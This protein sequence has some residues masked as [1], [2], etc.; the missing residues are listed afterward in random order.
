VAAV[1]W[2]SKLAAAVLRGRLEQEQEQLA[3]Q[4]VQNLERLGPTFV[5]L[6]Q[7]LS[8]RPD[9]LPLPVMRELAKLQDNIEPFPTHEARAL[10]EA[11]LGRPISEI[12]SEFSEQ[13]IAAASL[14]QVRQL[15]LFREKFVLHR[16][17]CLS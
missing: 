5:K 6:G 3:R 1:P 12:F 7:V 8:I 14:A 15:W 2:I 16:A 13:P 17:I 9:V 11:E 10:V 4:A